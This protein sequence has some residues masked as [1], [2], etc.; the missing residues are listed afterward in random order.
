MAKYRSNIDVDALVA[1]DVHTHASISSRSPPDT[2]T[3]RME[4]GMAKYFGSSLPPAMPEIAQYYRDRHM[5]AVIFAVDAESAFG[6][7]RIANEEVAELAAENNDV[8]IPFASIDPAKGKL[9]VRE[10][11]RLIA[12]YGVRGF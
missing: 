2:C 5:A 8:L 4:E 6:A 10:A 9:G 7:P 12:D 3:L 11:R 1:I